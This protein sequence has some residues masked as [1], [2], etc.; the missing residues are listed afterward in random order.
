[1]V[2]AVLQH[3]AAVEVGAEQWPVLEMLDQLLVVV[4][5]AQLWVQL[6]ALVV[7]DSS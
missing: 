3:R 5:E 1:V 2:Q 4:V 7:L 6:E